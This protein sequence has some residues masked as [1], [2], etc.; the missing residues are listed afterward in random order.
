[1]NDLAHRSE[2]DN[3]LFGDPDAQHWAERFVAVRQQIMFQHARDI[4]GDEEALLTW[5][6]GAIET[7][8]MVERSTAEERPTAGRGVITSDGDIVVTRAG[9]DRPIYITFFDQYN[10]WVQ[11]T[12]MGFP[13]NGQWCPRH[14]APGAHGFNGVGASVAMMEAFATDIDTRDPEELNRAM[15]RLVGE[16]GAICCWVGDQEM[17]RIWQDWPSTVRRP[18]QVDAFEEER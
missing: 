18:G 8:R 10:E 3:D 9:D 11:R 17:Y 16:Y 13:Q 7:G 12:S 6:A 5:F 4:A 14:W 15:L 2:N 1:M